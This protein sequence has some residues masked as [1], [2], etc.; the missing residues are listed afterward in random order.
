M[1]LKGLVSNEIVQFSQRH[2]VTFT[3]ADARGCFNLDDDKGHPW[4]CR[5]PT[6]HNDNDHRW[7]EFKLKFWMTIFGRNLFICTLS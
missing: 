3:A 5:H 4:N 7:W 1:Q 6:G 2:D